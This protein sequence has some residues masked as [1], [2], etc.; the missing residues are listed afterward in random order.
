L[1]GFRFESLRFGGCGNGSKGC[2][3][4]N[5][6]ESKSAL[7][8]ELLSAKPGRRWAARSA[9]VVFEMPRAAVVAASAA[10]SLVLVAVAL[11]VGA[12]GPVEEL[13]TYV[14]PDCTVLPRSVCARPGW[15]HGD[16]L[17]G[18]MASFI[19]QQEQHW[20]RPE[21]KHV[22][23]SGQA[24]QVFARPAVSVRY[25]HAGPSWVPRKILEAF[26]RDGGD[27]QPLRVERRVV[28]RDAPPRGAGHWVH[29]PGH[30]VAVARGG[31]PPTVTV[32]S[33]DSAR[34]ITVSPRQR[35]VAFAAPAPA[36]AAV[37]ARPAAAACAACAGAATP[38]ALLP[39]K[40][41]VERVVSAVDQN[42][43]LQEAVARARLLAAEANLAE[44]HSFLQA[45]RPPPPPPS[46]TDWTRLVPPPVL[47]G[48]ASSL[49][50][51]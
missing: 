3:G 26:A 44:F 31:A 47:T 45:R 4:L 6:K 23:G 37:V 42:L 16:R 19:A 15:R 20:R 36:P 7:L 48:H 32:A 41:A 11:S 34:R 24:R 17:A 8:S 12:A 18:G 22:S 9:R 2:G 5:M 35:I 40:A 39:A 51:Y 14:D 27:A 21:G 13:G 46:R 30:E 50:P 43:V 25:T 33:S 10:G 28:V 49:L 29:I 38:R 1:C